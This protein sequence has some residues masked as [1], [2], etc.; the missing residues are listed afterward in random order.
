M[1]VIL[2]QHII[3]IIDIKSYELVLKLEMNTI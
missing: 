2:D 1:F 3:D